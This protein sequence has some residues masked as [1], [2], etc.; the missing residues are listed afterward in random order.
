MADAASAA[1]RPHRFEKDPAAEKRQDFFSFV[2]TARRLLRPLGVEELARGFIEPLVGVRAEEVALRL[3][4][5]RGKT[6][7]PV[8]VEVRERGAE[9]GHSHTLLDCSANG[10]APIRLRPYQD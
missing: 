3:E 7:R 6:I 8:A 5:I 2:S 4:Q 10:F 9:G 1:T